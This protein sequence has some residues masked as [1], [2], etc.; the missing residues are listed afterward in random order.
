MA[1]SYGQSIHWTDFDGTVR[2]VAVDHHSSPNEAR[3]AVIALAAKQGWTAPKWWQF[4]R[5]NDTRV[6]GG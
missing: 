1:V 3:R 6:S 5:W 4:W 2:E